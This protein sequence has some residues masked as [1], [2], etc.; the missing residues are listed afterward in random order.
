MVT[1]NH[2]RGPEE[3]VRYLP[4]VVSAGPS[5]R[6]AAARLLRTG[7]PDGTASQDAV[8]LARAEPGVRSRLP[9]P[10]ARRANRSA[11]RTAA[12]AAAAEPASL[13]S[14]ERPVRSRRY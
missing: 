12:Y 4:A 5:N 3:T 1:M 9:H 11:R 7:V 2:A 8:E 10:A 13:G 6:R 14:G